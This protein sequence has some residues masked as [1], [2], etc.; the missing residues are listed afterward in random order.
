MGIADDFVTGVMVPLLEDTDK[1]YVLAGVISKGY[2][3]TSL[4]L[5]AVCLLLASYWKASVLQHGGKSLDQG[6]IHVVGD[7]DY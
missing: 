3:V 2:D 5:V 6:L 4:W 1:R 7:V